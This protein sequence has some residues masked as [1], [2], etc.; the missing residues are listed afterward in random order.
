MKRV[1]HSALLITALVVSSFLGGIVGSWLFGANTASAQDVSQTIVAQ[2]V[3]TQALRIV[4][5]D[6]NMR[7]EVSITD[8]GTT[9][10]WLYG[11]D[12]DLRAFLGTSADGTPN[13]FLYDPGSD[14]SVRAALGLSGDGEPSLILFDA[15][16]DGASRAAM[17]LFDDGSAGLSLSDSLGKSGVSA[18]VNQD[19]SP[20]V[21]ITDTEGNT[22]WGAP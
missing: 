6:G 18:Q 12:Q 16:Q 2:E 5:T 19:G 8:D 11:G 3:V 9:G 14:G 4:D 13:L 22:V 1:T 15:G 17:S 20:T 7:A 21:L 10:V